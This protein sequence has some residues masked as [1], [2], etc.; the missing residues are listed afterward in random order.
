LIRHSDL[1]GKSSRS[2]VVVDYSGLP[3][4]FNANPKTDTFVW[5]SGSY[6]AGKT[7][8]NVSV[9]QDIFSTG[10]G[11]A[12]SVTGIINGD[13]MNITIASGV[14]IYGTGGDGGIGAD[15]STRFTPPTTGGN[16]IGGGTAMYI[17]CTGATVNIINNGVLAAGGGG[18]AGSSGYATGINYFGVYNQCGTEYISGDGG[19]GGAGGFY[20]GS[21]GCQIGG[22]G[23]AA[24]GISSSCSGPFVIY[25][26]GNQGLNG[27]KTVGGGNTACGTYQTTL[28]AGGNLGGAGFNGYSI[29]GYGSGG[30]GGAGGS[31]TVGFSRVSS[32]TGS[33][34]YYGAVN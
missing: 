33:G 31:V 1:Y 4:M 30:T 6:V 9:G 28:G 12:F 26:K 8:F 5:T 32:Y 18:G 24:G 2:V 29:S 20:T 14:G 17:A 23:G 13:I 10:A 16:G 15:N 11:A 34:T 3:Y 7:T 22:R 25:T 21:C 27:T 19:G